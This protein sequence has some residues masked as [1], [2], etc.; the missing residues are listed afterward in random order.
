[1]IH[2]RHLVLL[3]VSSWKYQHADTS[4]QV[5][6]YTSETFYLS[7]HVLTCVNAVV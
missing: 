3:D 1:M 4:Q 2:N 6:N 7:C 5:F